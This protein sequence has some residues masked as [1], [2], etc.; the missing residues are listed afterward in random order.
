MSKAD[1]DAAAIP[2]LLICPTS[3]PPF[4]NLLPHPDP[5]LSF[6]RS[7]LHWVL[8]LKWS[9]HCHTERHCSCTLVQHRHHHAESKCRC[10]LNKRAIF[11]QSQWN[12]IDAFFLLFW[13]TQKRA[14]N[15]QWEW[16]WLDWSIFFTGF[17]STGIGEAS[18]RSQ[19]SLWVQAAPLSPTTAALRCT[20]MH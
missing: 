4:L 5:S 6:L 15:K 11:F 14:V 7:A 3:N 13:A 10:L 17:F 20:A 16:A 8:H 2:L 18:K 9:E 12:I 19:Q 1:R